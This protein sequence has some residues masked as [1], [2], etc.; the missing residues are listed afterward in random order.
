MRSS[1][2]DHSLVDAGF[3]FACKS[4]AVRAALGP[5]LDSYTMDQETA[6][7][8]HPATAISSHTSSTD[9]STFDLEASSLERDFEDTFSSPEL[10]DWL[11]A[12]LYDQSFQDMGFDDQQ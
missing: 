5:L 12:P 9:Y 3:A 2:D 1:P 4:E 10:L 11:E 7:H 6:S 8:G